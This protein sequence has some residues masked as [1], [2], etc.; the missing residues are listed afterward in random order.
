M[1]RT[2]SEYV[3]QSQRPYNVNVSNIIYVLIT[4]V[5]QHLA[6]SVLRWVTVYDILFFKLNVK[7][8]RK[9]IL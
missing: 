7:Y 6:L 8:E 5:K 3:N 1:Q 9:K 2:V 4:K